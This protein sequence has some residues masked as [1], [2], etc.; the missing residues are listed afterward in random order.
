MFKVDF[1]KYQNDSYNRVKGE[2]VIEKKGR[3]M[4]KKL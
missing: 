2:Q 4:G 1:L 3:Y